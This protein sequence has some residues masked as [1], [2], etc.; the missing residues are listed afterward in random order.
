[1]TS[2]KV[3][4]VFV[5]IVLTAIAIPIGRNLWIRN[6]WFDIQSQQLAAIKQLEAHPPSGWT[7]RA[8]KNALITPYNVWGNV[9]YHPDYSG[10]SNEGMRE[11]KRQLD[12]IVT[13]SNSGNS[14]HSVDR[15]FL[16]LL[17]RG[18]K[19]RFIIGYRDEFRSYALSVKTPNQ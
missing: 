19:A 4:F 1:M 3:I 13:E 10:I 18:R 15:V 11:L 14:I 6:Q 7:P 12:Q 5:T 8:W 16:L 17:D 9:T 2:R